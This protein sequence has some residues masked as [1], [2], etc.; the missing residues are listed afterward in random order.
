MGYLK[1][2]LMSY[3]EDEEAVKDIMEHIKNKRDYK[4]N[5][6]FKMIN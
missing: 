4:I 1:T 3:F 5:N 2:C 6:E